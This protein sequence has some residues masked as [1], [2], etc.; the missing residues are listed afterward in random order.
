[1]QAEVVQAATHVSRLKAVKPL[2]SLRDQATLPRRAL[3]AQYRG[4]ALQVVRQNSPVGRLIS[5]ILAIFY[6]GTTIHITI[7]SKNA[8]YCPREGR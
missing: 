4:I 5:R 6:G 1:M 7:S 8:P 2:R 3:S